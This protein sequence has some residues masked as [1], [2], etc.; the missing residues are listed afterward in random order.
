MANRRKFDYEKRKSIIVREALKGKS[1]REIAKVCEEEG[2]KCHYN[3]VQQVMNNDDVQKVLK[4][5]YYRMAG[6][7]TKSVD[8]IIKAADAFDKKQMSEDKK[9]SWEA[10]KLIAQAHGLLPSNTQSIVHQTYIANQT[11]NVIPPIIAELA[12]KHF[13]GMI[14]VNAMGTNPQI[15]NIIEV[16]DERYTKAPSEVSG[17]GQDHG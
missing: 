11:N 12:A 17:A 6:A 4:K 16:E 9:I 7:V 14:K 2:V 15:D 10:N 13:G 3:T 8:N 1:K 5:S